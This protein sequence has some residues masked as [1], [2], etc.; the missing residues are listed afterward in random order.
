MKKII[1]FCSTL[2]MVFSLGIVTPQTASANPICPPDFTVDNQV[3]DFIGYYGQNY[4]LSRTGAVY[5]KCATYYG[6]ANGQGY[7]SG[8]VAKQLLLCVDGWVRGYTIVSTS[9]EYYNYG[10]TTGCTNG[11]W[12]NSPVNDYWLNGP[13]TDAPFRTGT[14][15]YLLTTNGAVYGH[16]MPYYGGANGQGYFAGRTASYLDA[17]WDG[18]FVG[19][20]ITATSGEQYNY[21]RTTGCR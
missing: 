16:G 18:Y 13:V 19:Y 1:L 6:G 12:Y 15:G 21:G 2:L 4:I 3:A 5:T 9:N 11:I 10:R 17:C 14:G 7:F 8:R 20:R